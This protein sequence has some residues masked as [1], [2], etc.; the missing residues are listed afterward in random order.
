MQYG[1]ALTYWKDETRYFYPLTYK[2][3]N[4][5]VDATVDTNTVLSKLEGRP[6]RI[7][8]SIVGDAHGA[9]LVS[10]YDGWKSTND[11]TGRIY[12]NLS[13]IFYHVHDPGYEDWISAGGDSTQPTWG[14]A[15]VKV[16]LDGVDIQNSVSFNVHFSEELESPTN[17]T[18]AVSGETVPDLASVSV[19]QK[20]SLYLLQR[21]PVVDY[22]NYNLDAKA[23][24]DIVDDNYE[25]VPNSG[26]GNITMPYGSIGS[27]HE[28]YTQAIAS[29]FYP[30]SNSTDTSYRN[31]DNWEVKQKNTTI[32]IAGGTGEKFSAKQIRLFTLTDG[33]T[34]DEQTERKNKLVGT[35]I[36]GITYNGNYDLLYTY[37]A[38]DIASYPSRPDSK[39]KKGRTRRFSKRGRRRFISISTDCLSQH[40]HI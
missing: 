26:Y 16:N 38:D 15:S 21:T 17:T 20:I 28:Q 11:G 19:D 22:Y 31:S 24:V 29:I 1:Q 34:A 30:Q 6:V 36:Y 8:A 27:Q 39:G 35:Q 33:L 4:Q 18:D 32:G 7:Y 37:G 10:D 13:D 2:L 12:K 14:M 9:T 40:S 5:S 25:H 3:K 23:Y